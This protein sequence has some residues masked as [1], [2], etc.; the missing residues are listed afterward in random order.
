MFSG[1]AS[2]FMD[3]SADEHIRQVFIPCKIDY[4]G[5]KEELPSYLREHESSNCRAH[6]LLH[7]SY[8]NEESLWDWI[9]PLYFAGYRFGKESIN[10]EANLT[11]SNGNHEMKNFEAFCQGEKKHFLFG[12]SDM[13]ETETECIKSVKETINQQLLDWKTGTKTR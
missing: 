1:C 10:I 4:D 8:I 5:N 12:Q 2:F 13:N 6:Y 3:D 9:N 7:K 11:I